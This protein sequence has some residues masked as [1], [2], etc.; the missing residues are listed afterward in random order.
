MSQPIGFC[1]AQLGA[2]QH[3]KIAELLASSGQ[4]ALLVTDFWNYTRTAGRSCA[5]LSGMDRLIR[6]SDR[7]SPL[8]PNRLVRIPLRMLAEAL[9]V[10]PPFILRRAVLEHAA[11]YGEMFSRQVVRFLER[12]R[13]S[14]FGFC[15][16]S[17]EALRFS[18]L[19]GRWSVLDQ[20]DAITEEEEIVRQECDAFPHL[21]PEPFAP[22][23]A[24]IDRVRQ[25]WELADRIIVNSDWTRN[26][27]LR[28][29]VADD[30]IRVV[31]LSFE[32][33][34]AVRPKRKRRILRVLWLGNL[35]LTKGLPYAVEAA[36]QME[37]TPVEFTFVGHLGVRLDRLDL[38]ANCRIVGPVPRSA[39][40]RL[41]AEHDVL[42]FCTLS[43]GFGIVQLEAMSRGL[44]V[45]ATTNCGSVVEDH[46]SGILV[47]PRCPEDIVSAIDELA[48][49][50]DVFEAMSCEALARVSAFS[51]SQVEKELIHAIAPPQETDIRPCPRSYD[52][53]TIRPTR[54]RLR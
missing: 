42:L 20:Y 2:R 41:Y 7:F 13:C 8:I 27:L 47:R 12:S 45:I 9:R 43:D 24:Y 53:A 54:S 6:A 18:R 26:A 50:P 5:Q 40:G 32:S 22:S 36:R 25:E 39:T 48:S 10:R 17:L 33:R 52:A 31:N 3:Y 4:L 37:H 46:V 11:R 1:Q 16:E 49:A 34:A 28:A 21:A 29:G 51:V 15:S 35:T 14:Y 38:P 30:R 23:T 19:N 44:P